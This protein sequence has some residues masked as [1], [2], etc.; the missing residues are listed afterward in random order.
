MGGGSQH[1]VYADQLSDGPAWHGTVRIT[2]TLNRDDVPIFDPFR[3]T[4]TSGVGLGLSICRFIVN[5]HGGKLWV[6]A[7]EPRGALFQFT[8][9]GTQ[10]NS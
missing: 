10:V 4:K 7:N 2:L 5:G 6:S 3:T 1:G 8:L 9:P